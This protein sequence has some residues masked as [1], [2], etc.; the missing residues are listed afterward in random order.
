M[1]SNNEKSEKINALQ[2]ELMGKN[3]SKMQLEFLTQIY[4]NKLA[5]VEKSESEMK[6]ELSL[7]K[8]FIEKNHERIV[9]LKNESGKTMDVQTQLIG[10]QNETLFFEQQETRYR[11]ALKLFEEE[12]TLLTAKDDSLSDQL[13]N[14]QKYLTIK[15]K[16][17]NAAND[18]L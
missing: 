6:H 11:E 3:K 13:K 18:S 9:N 2:L 5:Q 16:Q 8:S 15:E 4:Q 14:L 7:T 10:L 1:G 12:K 17:I